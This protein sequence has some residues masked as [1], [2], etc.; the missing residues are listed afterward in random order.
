MLPIL[1]R[2]YDIIIILMVFLGTIIFYMYLYNN[3]NSVTLINIMI[4][5]IG[6]KL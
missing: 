1:V 2:F 3:N 4:I 5:T 6:K